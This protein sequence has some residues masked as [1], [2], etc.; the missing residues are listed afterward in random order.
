MNKVVRLSL[1]LSAALVAA[2]VMVVPSAFSATLYVDAANTGFE[3]GTLANP[4]NT[5]QEAMDAALED[6]TISVARGIY[7]GGLQLNKGIQLI[8]QEGPQVT[9]L[10]GLSGNVISGWYVD[11]YHNYYIKGFT[12]TG[13]GMVSLVRTSYVTMENCIFRDSSDGF[14]FYLSLGSGFTARNCLLLNM[15]GLAV[16]SMF[17]AGPRFENVTLDRAGAGFRAVYSNIQLFNTSISNV[18]TAFY[19]NSGYWGSVSGS[20]VNLWNNQFVSNDLSLVGIANMTYV[21]PRFVA[22]PEDYRLRAGSPL[23]DAGIDIGL[24]YVGAAPDI[25]AYEYTELT[26]PEKVE[27]LAASFAGVPSEIVRDPAEQRKI[28]L[29]QKFEAILRMVYVTEDSAGRDARLNVLEGCLAKLSND[30]L[31]KVD[32]N[33]GGNPN[34]DWLENGPEK[35]TLYNQVLSVIADIKREFAGNP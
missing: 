10:D 17:N 23:I 33:S 34:N 16:H 35:I 9:I 21:D 24:P 22:P 7:Y 28:A 2:L 14:A 26:L 30:I 4:F 12:L 31:A 25:G 32:G 3:D 19:F 27:N 1:S 5:I 13:A 8:S 29:Y 15:P 6:D 11:S 18:D 20:N